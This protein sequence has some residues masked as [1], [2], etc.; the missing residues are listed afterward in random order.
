[1]RTPKAKTAYAIMVVVPLKVATDAPATA[2][3]AVTTVAI[4]VRG[5]R[6]VVVRNRFASQYTIGVIATPTAAPTAMFTL[7]AFT[8]FTHAVSARRGYYGSS[9]PARE[10]FV[11]D[12]E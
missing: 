4:G 3:A 1:V 8:W 7:P 6:A 9:H 5:I 2:Q 12:L 11:D 10:D